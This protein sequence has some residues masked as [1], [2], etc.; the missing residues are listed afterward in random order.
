M[1]PLAVPLTVNGRIVR[2]GDIAEVTRGYE[3]PPQALIRH[4][5]E[6]ALLLGVVMTPHYNGLTLGK[7]LLDA[8]VA[9]RA[10]LPLGLELT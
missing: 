3:D 10:E 5:G 4:Q 2:L 8:Q 7:T 9:L 1:R 6:P